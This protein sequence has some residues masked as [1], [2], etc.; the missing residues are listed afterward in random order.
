MEAQT[1]IQARDFCAR[2][3]EKHYENF[4]VGSRW[5]PAEIRPDIHAVYAFARTADDFADE[6]EHEGA[7]LE[8]LGEWR[9]LLFEAAEGKA[10]HPV[11]VALSQTI[12]RRN[13][14]VK[15]LDD[16][17]RAFEMDVRQNRHA[18]FDALVR[19]ARLSANPVGRIVLWLHGYRDED[20]FS[21]SDHICS[22]LQ[23]TNFWQ[24]VAVDWKKN[25]VYL[26][27]EDMARF[28]YTED[29]LARGVADERFKKLLTWEIERTRKIFGQGRA[30]CD[31]VGS[32][33]RME[34]RLVWSG[35]TR[36]LDRIEKNGCDVFRRRPSLGWMDKG[37]MLVKALTWRKSA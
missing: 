30:L 20:R 29:D 25:R 18:T 9:R 23:F 32:G 22:A 34:L 17:I 5:I 37:A 11:F 2:L 13:V 26:P 35:G 1:A 8:K 12:R 14:P 24:D 7:R 21:L 36:V 16:L 31:R 6:A 27:Q 10:E 33:L 4:P 28:G 15:W 3:A 19:Y